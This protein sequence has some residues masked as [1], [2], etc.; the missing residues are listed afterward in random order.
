MVHDSVMSRV[1][2][3]GTRDWAA[4]QETVAAAFFDREATWR[5][6]MSPKALKLGIFSS[7]HVAAGTHKER[8]DDSCRILF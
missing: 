8:E 4:V 6:G 1:P 2:C 7:A 5:D 3:V